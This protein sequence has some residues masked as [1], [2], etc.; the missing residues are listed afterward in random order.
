MSVDVVTAGETMLAL[1]GSGPLRLGGS[2]ATSIAGAE[3]NVAV[4]MSRLGH[5]VA[6]AGRVGDDESGAL[7]LR[8]L[9]A[10]GVECGGVVRDGDR[11]TG[12]LIFEKRLPDVTRVEYHRRDSAGSRW[13]A[14]DAERALSLNPRLVHVTGITPALSQEAREATHALVDGAKRQGATVSVDINFR[15]RLWSAETAAPHLR[16]LVSG[17]DIVIA[18][19]DELDLVGG[20][21]A[22]L[23]RAGAREVVVKNG[24]A[25]ATAHEADRT[26]T[27]PARRVTVVD[28][29]GAGDAFSAGYLSGWLDELSLEERMERAHTLG[30][31]AVAS[32]GDWE[33][34]PR[35]DELDL[36]D[37][38]SGDAVR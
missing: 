24:V 12:M 35:R 5:R 9:A 37:L 22:A 2:L 19:P 38:A 4:G 36:I 1:R 26:V 8:S 23:I 6:W 32:H 29:I 15:S 17:A 11:A 14:A 7:V 13:C 16:R 20:D 25:G 31:F 3:S 27:V 34:L 21:P 10:E 30:A 18:S 33:G 28:S